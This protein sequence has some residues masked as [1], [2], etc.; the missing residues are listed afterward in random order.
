MEACSLADD[1][2]QVDARILSKLALGKALAAADR[3]AEAL[4]VL[5][6]TVDAAQRFRFEKE[7]K[8]ACTAIAEIH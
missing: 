8:E 3:S 1:A 7:A 6:E 2:S 5:H 4:R